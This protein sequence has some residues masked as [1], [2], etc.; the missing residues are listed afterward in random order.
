NAR[1]LDADANEIR[2][3][4]VMSYGMW[5][6][7]SGGTD[8]TL[9][10][11]EDVMRG[12]FKPRRDVEP[13]AFDFPV[14]WGADPYKDENWQFRL[15]ALYM[16]D[17]LL[18]AEDR[19]GGEHYVRAALRILVDWRRYHAAGEEAK[20]SWYNMA[21]GMRSAKIAYIHNLIVREY[22]NL[23][24][25]LVE[26]MFGE[27]AAQHVT[28]VLDGTIALRMTNHGLFQVHGVVALC[29]EFGRIEACTR[30]QE[31]A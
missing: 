8:I 29:R 27:M 9:D 6:R 11:A 18:V 25:P 31:F 24:D 23:L 2:L 3:S 30:S 13:W 10:Y 16:V 14:D 1:Q 7:N 26:Q 22:P 5:Y 17:P 19:E 12:R 20:Y 15:H 4:D 21:V 28:P